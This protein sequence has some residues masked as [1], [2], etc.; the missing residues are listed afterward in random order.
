MTAARAVVFAYHDVGVRC[1]K[2]LISGGVSIP[3]VVTVADD[4]RETQWFASV[5]ATAADYGIRTIIPPEANTAELERD[6][7]ALQP[8]FIF[9]FY[10][11][12]ML[13]PGLLRSAMRGALNMHGSLLPRY[14]GRAP[15]NW[16]I[17]H[18]ERETGATLHYMVERA[19]AGDIVDQLAVPILQDDDARDVFG[20]VTVAA[21]TILARSLPG[22][23]AGTA[24]RKP[25]TLQAGQYFGRRTA[26]DGRIDW[27]QGASAIHNLV[28]AVAPPF[29]GAFADIRGERWWIHRT[30][31]AAGLTATP[32]QARLVGKAG[33]CYLECSDGQV[34]QILAAANAAG[35]IDPGALSA[36]LQRRAIVLL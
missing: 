11:R 23:V 15:V 32:G 33:R 12:S 2:A 25:Q 13:G 36:D 1:L 27:R 9:S 35:R 10:Y 4:P 28:R 31:I 14:R 29:P 3:L 18:G 8:D 19:D 21:E 16:A 26:E 34:L 30:R 6:V 7:A 24:P 22:L 20:K 5:A 17:L